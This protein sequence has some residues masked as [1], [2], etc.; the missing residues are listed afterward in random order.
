[1]DFSS[2]NF[3]AI[4]VAGVAAFVIGFLW[5]GPLFGNYWIK[6]QNI[7]ES[8]VDAMRAKGMGPM[9]PHMIAGFVQQILVAIV[10]AHLVNVLG[11]VDAMGAIV[12]AVLFWFG[13]I[14]MTLLDGVL[15]EKR[16]MEL[17]LF[18]NSYH[19]VRLIAIA[20]IVVLWK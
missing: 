5:H 14:A 1:M 6:L 9:I 20:L 8:E 10:V 11:I 3:L 4:L 12:L 15:W 2:L 19:L 7:P 17:Y 13:F 16:K 18:N